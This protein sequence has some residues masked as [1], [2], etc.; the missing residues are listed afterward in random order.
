MRFNKH[1][2]D[3]RS[4]LSIL[5]ASGFDKTVSKQLAIENVTQAAA[6]NAL[7]HGILQLAHEFGWHN[8]LHIHDEI[9]II[10]DKNQVAVLA[11]RDALLRVF[12]PKSNH[13][14]TWA[15]LI[16][17][18]EVSVTSSMWEDDLDLQPPTE[19]N[20]FKG[21]DRW[22]KIEQGTPDCLDNLP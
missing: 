1:A 13:P 14:M 5:K 3:S 2:K 15:V 17:P 12:G 18:D 20:K 19:K 22:R 16:K 10:C 6:R 9:M 7:C 11:A 8:I 21:F 4:R